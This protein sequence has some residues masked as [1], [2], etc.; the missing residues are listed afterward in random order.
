MNIQGKPVARF[1]ISAILATGVMVLSTPVLGQNPSST[2]DA[3]S[4]EKSSRSP[5]L[6]ST[7]PD[8]GD[9]EEAIIHQ[10]LGATSAARY[11]CSQSPVYV[12]QAANVRACWPRAAAAVATLLEQAEA[13]NKLVC[14]ADGELPKDP[15]WAEADLSDA[16]LARDAAKVG[17]DRASKAIVTLDRASVPADDKKR[18]TAQAKLVQVQNE[19]KD[20]EKTLEQA[21]KDLDRAQTLEPLR[22]K[23]SETFDSIVDSATPKDFDAFLEDE[24]RQAACDSLAAAFAESQQGSKEASEQR[25][26]ANAAAEKAPDEAH[27]TDLMRKASTIATA[28]TSSGGEVENP[29][30]PDT[31]ALAIMS[32]LGANKETSGSHAVMTLNLAALVVPREEKRLTLSPAVRNLFVRVAAPLESTEPKPVTDA[33]DETESAESQPNV[34]R[35]SV[36]LGT[37]LL[38]ASDPRLKPNRECYKKAVQFLPPASTATAEESRAKQRKDLFDVCNRRAAYEQRLALRAGVSII[39]N[40]D[41]NNPNTQPELYSGALV[42]APT[43]WIYTNLLYQGIVKPRKIQV[44]GA[45]VSIARNVGGPDSGVDAWSRV[46]IDTMFLVARTVAS[47]DW[48]WEWRIMP[49]ARVKIGDTVSQLGVGPRI[50][51]SGDTGLFATIA[52]SYDV[53]AL[54]DPLLTAPAAGE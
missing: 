31:V 46:G 23:M 18:D 39:S 7:D 25:Q 40:A 22:L 9:P 50:L 51:G 30:A 38:D 44:M 2:D 48:D 17:V 10:A 20:A 24:K 12:A 11:A 33:T 29:G 14:D 43:S 13:F 15:K 36:V 37:S 26:A 3:S 21:Q 32:A 4:S 19:L 6:A 52:L 8:F 16:K 5:V 47:D 54:M 34:K 1:G 41:S 49:T 35:L 42:Y 53:D 27:A 28:L 45:G